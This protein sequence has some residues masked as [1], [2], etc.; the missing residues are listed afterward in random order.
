[1]VQQVSTLI[2]AIFTNK[3]A[4]TL[5]DQ[6][7]GDVMANQGGF[8]MSHDIISEQKPGDGNAPYTL[9]T[10]GNPIRYTAERSEAFAR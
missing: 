4:Q 9:N 6:E 2:I 10:A 5:Y 3:S 1:M 8:E 7:N